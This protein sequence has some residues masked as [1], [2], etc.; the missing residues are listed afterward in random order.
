MNEVQKNNFFKGISSSSAA[1]SGGGRQARGKR[2]VPIGAQIWYS[3]VGTL[4]TLAQHEVHHERSFACGSGFSAGRNRLRGLLRR[5]LHLRF[6]SVLLH[7]AS[8]FLSLVAFLVLFT[9]SVVQ[10]PRLWVW[11]CAGMAVLLSGFLLRLPFLALPPW[12]LLPWRSRQAA[13]LRRA[14]RSSPRR[15]RRSSPR[16]SWRSPSRRP[17]LTTNAE[18]RKIRHQPMAALPAGRS[19]PRLAVRLFFGLPFPPIPPPL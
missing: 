18:G 5:A 13:T 16:R 19:P 6:V 11:G 8:L 9:V 7:H 4:V 12:S 10:R 14:E 17:P 3:V 1:G 15:P 2:P